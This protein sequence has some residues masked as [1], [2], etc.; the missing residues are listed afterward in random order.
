MSIIVKSVDYL[1]E[2]ATIDRIRI[3]VFQQEQGVNPALE[4]D[5]LDQEADHLLA[6]WQA[7]GVGTAR[8]RYFD[9]DQVKIERL[10]VLKTARGR[11][12]GQKLMEFALHFIAAQQQYP[13]IIIHAQDYLRAFY[14]KLGFSQV[15]DP[16]DEAGILHVKMIKYL[17]DFPRKVSDLKNHGINRKNAF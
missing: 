17:T 14:H 6:Y 10:A 7:Q 15:G 16:F 1:T 12:I 4:F 5:G 2:K 8:I 13:I 9:F 3:A 11:G